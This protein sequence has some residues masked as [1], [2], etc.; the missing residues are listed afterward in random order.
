MYSGHIH[1]EISCS[2]STDKKAVQLGDNRAPFR[3]N[4]NWCIFILSQK[5]GRSFC[6]HVL[7]MNSLVAQNNRMCFEMHFNEK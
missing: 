2:D 4:V 3:Q 1:N 7:N 5:P 6:V